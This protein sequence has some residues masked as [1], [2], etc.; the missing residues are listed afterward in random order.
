VID[1][2]GEPVGGLSFRSNGRW[3]QGQR[4]LRPA[5]DRRSSSISRPIR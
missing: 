1:E 5:S 2:F 4:R 3:N